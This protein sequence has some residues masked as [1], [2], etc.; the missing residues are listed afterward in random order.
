[1]T[2]GGS[3]RR[4]RM[5]LGRMPIPAR[6][7]HNTL[8]EVAWTI[9][10]VL[11]L[12]GIAIPSFRILRE[13]LVIPPHDIV[14]K[15]TGNSWYWNYEYPADQGGFRFDSNMVDEKDLKPGQPRLLTVDNEM[16]AR[17][18][19]RRDPRA[20]QRDLVPGRPG[21]RLLRPVLG[22]V[23]QRPSLHA[24]HRPRRERAAIPGVARGGEAEVRRRGNR[25]AA[26]QSALV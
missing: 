3:F 19:A 14:V 4:R 10:P 1:M 18:K 12:I 20:P 21:G 15:A 22:T 13:Q 7:T 24:D 2:A 9:V 11:I 16:V 6:T 25:D 26:R 23:R 17:P 8:L 5:S